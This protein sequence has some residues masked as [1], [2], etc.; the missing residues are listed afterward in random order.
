MLDM[1]SGLADFL[2]GV[3]SEVHSECDA[4]PAKPAVQAPGMLDI[5]MW[6]GAS[7]NHMGMARDAA[8]LD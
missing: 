3:S 5:D 7:A 8:P 2:R 1:D 4:L 6:T